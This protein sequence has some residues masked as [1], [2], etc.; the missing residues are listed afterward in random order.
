[1]KTLFLVRHAKSSWSDP[2]LADRERPLAGR[3]RR[4]ARKMGRRLAKRKVRPDLMVSSPATRALRTARIMARK[5]HYP[6]RQITVNDRL[7]ACTF[8]SLLRTVRTLRNRYRRVMLFGHNPQITD[9][10]RHFS[11]T[12]QRMPTGAVAGMTF[13]ADAWADVGPDTLQRVEF[14]CPRKGRE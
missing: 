5:L 12:I 6:P 10:A 14:D 1:M 4:A 8:A 7:Y 13:D 11:G 3:G 2:T 9:L